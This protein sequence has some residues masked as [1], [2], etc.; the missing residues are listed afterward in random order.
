[1]P[2]QHPP[3]AWS[4]RGGFARAVLVLLTNNSVSLC[5]GLVPRSGC[6]VWDNNGP[7]WFSAGGSPCCHGPWCCVPCA[8]QGGCGGL[9]AT[10]RAGGVS[11]ALPGHR[12]PVGARRAFGTSSMLR[13][14]ELPAAAQE[15][16]TLLIFPPPMCRHVGTG[17]VKPSR[18]ESCGRDPGI[19]PAAPVGEWEHGH[20]GDFPVNIREGD[21]AASGFLLVPP[22]PPSNCASL[23]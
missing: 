4:R 10:H 2:L 23:T 11:P 1:M 5:R 16:Q 12:R 17:W 21:G 22:A 8:G 19:T 15:F 20:S 3:P 7:G 9:R 13:G 18:G 14:W 6:S